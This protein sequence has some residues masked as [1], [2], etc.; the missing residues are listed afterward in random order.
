MSIKA[1]DIEIAIASGKMSTYLANKILDHI[2][3]NDTYTPP[4]NIYVGLAT[5]TIYDSDTGSTITEPTTG[6]YA[7]IN[8][9]AWNIASSGASSNDGAISFAEPSASQGTAVDTALIDALT[10]GNLL[11]YGVLDNAVEINAGDTPFS[12]ADEALDITLT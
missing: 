3:I 4:T 2:F 9:N 8:H 5:E 11:L 7:R 12:F 10:A 6:G 1:Q